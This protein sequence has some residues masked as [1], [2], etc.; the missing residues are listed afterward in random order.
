MMVCL[1]PV[2]IQV[3]NCIEDCHSQC[4]PDCLQLLCV[5][6][7]TIMSIPMIMNTLMIM[8]I[9]ARIMRKCRTVSASMR[10]LTYFMRIPA[11]TIRKSRTA[12]M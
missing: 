2:L 8:R 7:V 10:Q 3:G 9:P 1:L 6:W 4:L 12:P 5:I 11:R